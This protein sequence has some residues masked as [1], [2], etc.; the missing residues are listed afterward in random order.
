MSQ[1][2]LLTYYLII[3]GLI[4]MFHSTLKIIQHEF[5]RLPIY[6]REERVT[7]KWRENGGQIEKGRK[8]KREELKLII[9]G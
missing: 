1:R 2:L 5:V 7:E 3:T 6:A 4:T 8:T 9:D